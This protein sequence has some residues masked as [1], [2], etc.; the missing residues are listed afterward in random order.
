MTQTD[1]N[2]LKSLISKN[3]SDSNVLNEKLNYLI[4]QSVITINN[5][6]ILNGKINQLLDHLKIDNHSHSE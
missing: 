6:N 3:V 2:Q 4:N 5:Q 1:L